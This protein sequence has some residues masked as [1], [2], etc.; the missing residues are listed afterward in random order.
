MKNWPPHHSSPR[1]E[2]CSQQSQGKK[3]P[4]KNIETQGAAGRKIS[5][6]SSGI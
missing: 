3:I 2:D 6:G 1:G 4:M 5:H